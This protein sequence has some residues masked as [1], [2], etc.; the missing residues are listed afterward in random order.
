MIVVN[1]D[2]AVTHPGSAIVIG[3]GLPGDRGWQGHVGREDDGRYRA[4]LT[5]SD[6]PAVDVHRDAVGWVGPFDPE[7][8]SDAET[9]GF[10]AA[11][12]I[13]AKLHGVKRFRL[14][15]GYEYPRDPHGVITFVDVNQ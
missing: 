4:D 7:V 12:C 1:V 3:S 11:A 5:V 13:L 10:A 14:A 15:L 9:L 6:V 2:V 8:E